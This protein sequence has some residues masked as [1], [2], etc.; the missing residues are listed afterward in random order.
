MTFRRLNGKQL[1]FV[2]ALRDAGAVTADTAF[3]IDK[4]ASIAPDELEALVEMGVISRVAPYRYHV[5]PDSRHAKLIAALENKERSG[6]DEPVQGPLKVAA[7]MKTML[8][9]I[10]VLLIPI[11][12]LRLL[13]S[14]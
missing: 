3:T 12:L 1:E 8:F 7:L 10:L 4:D 13:G 5:R 6:V 11:V 2:Q 9:W 14:G